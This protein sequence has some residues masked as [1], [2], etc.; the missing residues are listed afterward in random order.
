MRS[1]IKFLSIGIILG[2]IS[3]GGSGSEGSTDTTSTSQ[4]KTEQKAEKTQDEQTVDQSNI[5]ASQR[6]DLENKGIGPVKNVELDEKIDRKL[7]V[8][9]KEIYDVKCIACHNVDTKLIGPPQK[10]IMKKRTP[11]WVMN[12]I[13]NPTEM[14]EKDPLAKDLLEEYNGTPM[15]DQNIT[16][17]EARALVEY[18]RT[19]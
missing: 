16:R 7:A 8:K 2:V 18:F 14:L 19:L 9:G 13:M 11:E 10:G 3:C 4:Q 1:I 12:M 6:V 15:L 5:P 17:E